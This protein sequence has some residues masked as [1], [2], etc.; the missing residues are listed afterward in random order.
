MAHPHEPD[1]PRRHR[2]DVRPAGARLAPV[3]R[4]RGHRRE[5]SLDIADFGMPVLNPQVLAVAEEL[6]SMVAAPIEGAPLRPRQGRGLHRGRRRFGRGV[7]PSARRRPQDPERRP[8]PRRGALRR[9]RFQRGGRRPQGEHLPQGE[10][11]R[12][13]QPP[14]RRHHWARR[15]L[16][17][18]GTPGGLSLDYAAAHCSAFASPTSPRKCPTVP[19]RAAGWSSTASSMWSIRDY[20][21][22]YLR[23]R[24][25]VSS[26]AGAASVNDGPDVDIDG[27]GPGRP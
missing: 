12:L 25:V 18:S 19:R 21:P 20:D 3:F 26:F 17:S 6:E 8:R 13:H 5:L 24:S 23:D 14:A 27:T 7:L 1:R 16:R 2:R 11:V 10:R 22:N 9:A 15:V 4:G